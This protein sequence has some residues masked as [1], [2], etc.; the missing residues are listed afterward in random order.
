MHRILFTFL[1]IGLFPNAI[2]AQQ[3]SRK[4]LKCK[5]TADSNDL[6]GIYIFNMNTQETTF[7]EKGGYFSLPVHVG[8]T[9]MLSSIQF[10][11]LKYGVKEDDLCKDLLF[12]KMTP[13][14]R[15]IQEVQV[16]RYDNINAIALGIVSKNVKSYTPAERKLRTATGLDAQIGLNTAITLDPLFNMLSG[17]TAMLQKELIVERKEIML[18]KIETMFEKEYFTDKL[19]IPTEY[20]KGFEYYLVENNRFAT[21]I[22]DKNKTLATFLMGEFAVS[23]LEIIACEKN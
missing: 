20:V 14:L 17:R 11:A 19:K 10:K 3:A 7:T 21:A 8:D 9:L 22:G 5:V 4:V 2:I 23:Y 15:Q 1:L 16:V 6:D 12:L 18:H 13:L